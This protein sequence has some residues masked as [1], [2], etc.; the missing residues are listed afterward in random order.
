MRARHSWT[1]LV[2]LLTCVV[3]FRLYPQHNPG[4]ATFTRYLVVQRIH[5]INGAQ[6]TGSYS[7]PFSLSFALYARR[8]N[9]NG[10]QGLP[11]KFYDFF[12]DAKINDGSLQDSIVNIINA[13]WTQLTNVVPRQAL[14]GYEGDVKVMTS[15]L[16]LAVMKKSSNKFTPLQSVEAMFRAADEN[17]DGELS[18]VEWYALMSTSVC[19]QP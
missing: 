17:Q 15:M 8:N 12:A 9:G 16:V 5:N 3:G 4:Y 11:D 1:Y 6:S 13:T 10:Q 14:S 7:F 2:L 18:I 19:V